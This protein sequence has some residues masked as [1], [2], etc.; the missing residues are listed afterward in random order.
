[1]TIYI[2]ST[3]LEFFTSGLRMY[4]IKDEGFYKIKK[5]NSFVRNP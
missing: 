1:M 5:K 2:I 4:K 3:F